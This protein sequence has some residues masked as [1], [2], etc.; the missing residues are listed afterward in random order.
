ML[1]PAMTMP[2]GATA[3]GAR[4]SGS[5]LLRGARA[6]PPATGSTAI[7]R[8]VQVAAKS[9]LAQRHQA[10]GAYWTPELIP[11]PDVDTFSS[12]DWSSEDLCPLHSSLFRCREEMEACSMLVPPQASVCFEDV[13]MAFTQEEWEQ[14]DLAQRTLYREVTLETWEHIVSLGL[15]LSKSDVI[16]QLEQEEDLCRAEQEA[17]RDGVSLC[18]PGW[19]AVAQSQLIATSASQ[20][21]AILLSQPPEYLGLQER[22]PAKSRDGTGPEGSERVWPA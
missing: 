14:L 12:N 1:P 13:A 19:S 22:G 16:S 3:T 6:R 20:F 18:R 7:G 21:Q 8:C 17:P 5:C 2:V 10:G 4:P 15:F 11:A 9:L